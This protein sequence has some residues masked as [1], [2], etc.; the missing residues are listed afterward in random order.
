MR[1]DE[2]QGSGSRTAGMTKCLSVRLV[3]A[4]AWLS[5]SPSRFTLSIVKSQPCFYPTYFFIF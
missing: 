5:V 3:E 4:A 1:R 2:G